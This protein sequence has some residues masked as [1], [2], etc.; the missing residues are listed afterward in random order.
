MHPGLD[1]GAIVASRQRCG[2]A[3]GATPSG[4]AP[5]ALPTREGDPK[6]MIILAIDQ[7]LRALIPPLTDEERAQLESNLRA[8]GCR[9]PL[10]V[11]AGELPVDATHPCQVRWV[12]Q[13]AL[14]RMLEE[15]SWL[16]PRCGEIRQR[17]YGL[18]DGHTR[19]EIWQQH[20][21]SFAIVEAQGVVTR[22]DAKLWIIR[23]QL[24]RRNLEAYQRAELALRLKGM[25]EAK[26]KAQQGRRTDLRLNVDGSSTSADSTA[27]MAAAAGV[28]RATMA[29]VKV[30]DAEADEPT[31]AA[32][33][34]GE[35]KIHGVYRGLRGSRPASNRK[36]T[37][38]ASAAA[39]MPSTPSAVA[40]DPQV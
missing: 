36:G 4:G 13:P 16:C 5:P 14:E 40:P 30:I 29:K 38:E 9:E 20:M 17:P 2:P 18:L 3:A 21:L 26:A 24:G 39:S 15:A 33:R 22:D 10:V 25:L 1:A 23:N 37:A 34:R 19:H 27:A 7:E 32:L 11:W 28:S 12:Y 8:E 31:K 35:R 6:T